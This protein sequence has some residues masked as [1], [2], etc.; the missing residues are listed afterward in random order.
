MKVLA[1]TNK[2]MEDVSS[3]E[4]E[5]LKGIKST[6]KNGFILFELEKYEDVFE[7][8]YLSRSLT[9]IVVLLDN[10]SFEETPLDELKKRINNYNLKDFIE[11]QRFAVQGEREGTHSFN[12]AEIGNEISKL[13]SSSNSTAIRDY[14]NPQTVF[15]FHIIDK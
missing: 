14:K 6:T 12:S 4:V 8:C 15:Y 10:F 13:I 11:G 5:S 3:K 1:T 9:K 7:I 2:G